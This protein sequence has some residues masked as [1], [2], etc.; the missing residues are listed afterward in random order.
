MGDR[1]VNIFGA[2]LFE[3]RGG[4]DEGQTGL[5][6]VVN[7]DEVAA[8]DRAIDPDNFGLVILGTV[9]FDD[10]D[11]VLAAGLGVVAGPVDTTLVGGDDGE[12]TETVCFQFFGK[13]GHRGEILV[14]NAEIAVDEL[15]MKIEGD[16]LIGPGD[17]ETF[18][19]KAGIDGNVR[20]VEAIGLAVT[21]IGDDGDNFGDAVDVEGVD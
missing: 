10:D 1:G 19:G 9:F 3:G 6:H 21:R 12:A 17:F 20:L 7:Q 13:E 18:D 5:D 11:V 14:G 15:A 4:G 16:E 2:L 8:F